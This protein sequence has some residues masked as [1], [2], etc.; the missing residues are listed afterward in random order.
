[1]KRNDLP[2]VIKKLLAQPW[3]REL[4][5]YIDH[6]KSLQDIVDFCKEKGFKTSKDSISKY[7]KYYRSKDVEEHNLD[8]YFKQNK[9][10]KLAF[11]QQE[12]RTPLSKSDKLK[13]D[14]EYM[15]LVI[16]AGAKNLQ[17]KLEEGEDVI[18]PADVFKAIELKDKLSE[19]MALGLTEHGIAYLQEITEEKYIR[20]L[21]HMFNY[22]EPTKR[23][24]V[25]DEIDEIE[26][27]FYKTTDYY[28]DYLR[29]KGYTEKEI[30][31]ALYEKTVNNTN[32]K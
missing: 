27:E 8:I 22:I 4:N 2:P 32:N 29:S 11:S 28:E 9:V 31:D 6:G 12:E 15:D 10:S 30:S 3:V 25:L 13:S 17:R 19:G 21:N 7:R 26:R 14:F 24:Q 18:K 1:M 20:I 23:N 16:Q 5:L